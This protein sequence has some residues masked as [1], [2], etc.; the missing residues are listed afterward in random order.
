MNTKLDKSD[1]QIVIET[2]TLSAVPN[3]SMAGFQRLMDNT[4]SL[5]SQ[6]SLHLGLAHAVELKPDAN[7][8]VG[9]INRIFKF[10]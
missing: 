3:K 10:G 2:R 6:L 1:S 9:Q 8:I 4:D 5:T 7:D